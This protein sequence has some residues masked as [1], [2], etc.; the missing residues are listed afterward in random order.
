[1]KPWSTSVYVWS[2]NSAI[3]LSGKNPFKMRAKDEEMRL[4]L[5]SESWGSTNKVVSLLGLR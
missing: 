4:L 3:E 5:V 1:M 2:S